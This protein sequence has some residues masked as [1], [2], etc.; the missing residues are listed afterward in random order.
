[1]VLGL[2][3]T[4]TNQTIPLPSG[5]LVGT[6]TAN[7]S[8][9]VR[10][11][12]E[13][14]NPAGT[15]SGI[16]TDT[17]ASSVWHGFQIEIRQQTQLRPALVDDSLNDVIYIAKESPAI[18]YAALITDTD[19]IPHDGTGPRLDGAHT[20]TGRLTHLGVEAAPRGKVN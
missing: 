15:A 20:V 11:C 12:F 5:Y 13:Y 6:N 19:V 4:A 9:S 1:M 8:G 3:L 17:I 7:A 14:K 10:A 2:L 16:L 18:L